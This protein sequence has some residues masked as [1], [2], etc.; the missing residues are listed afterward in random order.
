MDTITEQTGFEPGGL[1]DLAAG[2]PQV[3]HTFS[4]ARSAPNSLPVESRE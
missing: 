3:N 1:A 4:T 2:V